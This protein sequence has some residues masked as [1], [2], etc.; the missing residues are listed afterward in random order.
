MVAVGVV[1]MTGQ[2]PDVVVER[3]LMAFRV[4]CPK[5]ACYNSC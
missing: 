5:P 4:R 3:A 1:I 2:L